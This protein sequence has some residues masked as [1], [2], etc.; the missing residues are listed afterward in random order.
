MAMRFPAAV[1]LAI[2]WSAMA[3]PAAAAGAPSADFERVFPSAYT[4]SL[5]D[6]KNAYGDKHYDTAF[7]LFQRAACAG[8]KESQSALGRMYLLGQGVKREDLVGYAWL[9]VAAEVGLLGYQSIVGKLEGAMTPAQRKI[10]D[11]LGA[12]TVGLYGLAA[13]HMSCQGYAS[14][15]GHIIDTIMCTPE[16]EG[17]QALLRRCVAGALP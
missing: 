1:I 2:V 14:R 15:G 9:K 7:K 17:N 6:A 13:T 11:R 4:D 12:T 8:D 16:I 3:H 5:R 10:A